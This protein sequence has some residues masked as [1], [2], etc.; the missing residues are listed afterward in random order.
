MPDSSKSDVFSTYP[1]VPEPKVKRPRGRSLKEPPCCPRGHTVSAGM[2]FCPECGS[3]TRVPGP[4]K[5][6]NGHEF[7]EDAKFCAVCG[8]SLSAPLPVAPLTP[9][10]KI[11]KE[12]AHQIALEMGKVNPVT[13]FAPGRT[14]QGVS[15]AVIHFLV[16]G[17]TAFGNVWMRGQEIELWPGHPRWQEA[18]SWI[19]LDVPGQYARFG[20]QIFGNGPWPGARSYTAGTGHLQALK[21]VSGDGAVSEPTEEELKKADAAEQQR[22]RRVS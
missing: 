1:F 9:E 4:P 17:F 11:S 7:P 20:R 13:V 19:T 10:E 14:P 16:D 22:G 12:R 21:S 18:Q 6:P 15:S 3:E 5:C 2:K 8:V